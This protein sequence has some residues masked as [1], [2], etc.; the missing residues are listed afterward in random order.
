MSLFLLFKNSSLPFIFRFHI[1]ILIY[2]ICFSYQLRSL[3]QLFRGYVTFLVSWLE[4]KPTSFSLIPLSLSLISSPSKNIFLDWC[5]EDYW[6]TISGRLGDAVKKELGHLW[7]WPS[8]NSLAWQHPEET[9]DRRGH[10][11]PTIESWN[12]ERDPQSWLPLI[13]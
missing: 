6:M 4:C 10:Q 13:W 1:Q 5:G 3:T 7:L 11:P 8:Q 12:T 2:G 9:E